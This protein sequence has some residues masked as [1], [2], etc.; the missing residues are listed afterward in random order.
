MNQEQTACRAP[1]NGDFATKAAEAL[2][3]TAGYV[4]SHDFRSMLRDVQ[5]VARQNPM[6]ALIGATAF[7]VLIGAYLRRG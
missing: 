6:P 7:G 3:T 5:E 4:Q 2:G 1:T